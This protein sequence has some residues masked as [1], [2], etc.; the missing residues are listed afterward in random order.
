[1]ASSRP[2]RELAERAFEGPGDRRGQEV[3]GDGAGVPVAMR[4]LASASLSVDAFAG[5]A[6]EEVL[7]QFHE[8]GMGLLRVNGCGETTSMSISRPARPD[9]LGSVSIGRALTVVR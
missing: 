8:H 1:M 5:L 9:G 2:R 6:A 4:A 7:G 3:V